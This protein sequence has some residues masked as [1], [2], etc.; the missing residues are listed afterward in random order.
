MLIR[1]SMGAPSRLEAVTSSLA[2]LSAQ[3]A[4]VAA[5]RPPQT[6]A[7][8]PT[9]PKS[10]VSWLSG[11]WKNTGGAV[12]SSMPSSPMPAAAPKSSSWI[13]TSA[14]LQ[15]ASALAAFSAWMD[16]DPARRQAYEQLKAAFGED[17]LATL[18]IEQRQQMIAEQVAFN[19]TTTPY[20]GD[21]A[22]GVAPGAL[23]TLSSASS[24]S[25]LLLGVGAVGVLGLILYIA[26]RD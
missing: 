18:S 10:D 6:A 5:A 7:A 9:S 26:R 11:I 8:D 21:A 1:G 22:G 2:T 17:K 19:S 15:T 3:R 12:A 13:N 23:A 24:S 14:V 20:A 16:Q 25:K 4:A